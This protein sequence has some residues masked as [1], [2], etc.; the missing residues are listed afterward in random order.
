MLRAGVLAGLAGTAVMTAFQKL[1]EM[2]LT[3][4]DDSYAP[5]DFVERVLPFTPRLTRAGVA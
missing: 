5:A 2:P 1:V 3:G 4:R